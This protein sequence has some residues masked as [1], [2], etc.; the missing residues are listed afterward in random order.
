MMMKLVAPAALVVMLVAFCAPALDLDDARLVEQS[1]AVGTSD[2][3]VDDAGAA[4]DTGSDAGAPPLLAA[5]ERRCS[6][7]GVSAALWH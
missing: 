7:A 2:L 1:I 3:D 4:E 6:W 5:G